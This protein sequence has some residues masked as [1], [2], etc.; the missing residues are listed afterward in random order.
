MSQS[1][2]HRMPL[3]RCVLTV[4]LV[5]TLM[6]CSDGQNGNRNDDAGGVT[7]DRAATT[8]SSASSKP[9]P[10]TG[11]FASRCW[12]TSCWSLSLL[13]IFQPPRPLTI[14]Y[15]VLC[16]HN[17]KRKTQ[18]QPRIFPSRIATTLSPHYM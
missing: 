14:S 5:A 16:L 8:T 4:G 7:T 12:S 17:K 13:Q 18:R 3:V 11:A 9:K 6:A 10:G 1:C 15:S 2:F